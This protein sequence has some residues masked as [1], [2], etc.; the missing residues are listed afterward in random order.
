MITLDQ[1]HID[2]IKKYMKY[3]IEMA[4]LD[5]FIESISFLNDQDALRIIKF[6]A[7]KRK[8]QLTKNKDDIQKT[9]D[10]I[11]NDIGEP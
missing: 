6:Y 10:D 1:Q 7:K 9:I 5:E 2:K 11:S 8:T 4:Y 3:K